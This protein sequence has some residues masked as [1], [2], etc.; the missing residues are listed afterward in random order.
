[1]KH[2]LR[3][4]LQRLRLRRLKADKTTTKPARAPLPAGVRL[5]RFLIAGNLLAFIA[6]PIVAG[7]QLA[8]I[9]GLWPQA[10]AEIHL[11]P[12]DFKPPTPLVST[13]DGMRNPFDP[14][15]KPWQAAAPVVRR[16][17][18]PARGL[19]VTPDMHI[20]FSPEGPVRPGQ[21]LP[22]GQLRA[23]ETDRILLDTPLGPRSVEPPGRPHLH[24]EQLNRP[25][26]PAPDK[27]AR[28]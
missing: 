12:A 1:M 22:E 7:S 8:R 10:D 23:I 17:A 14:D 20:L 18:G 16:A 26:P 24:L 28:P 13:L 3:A 19:I 2:R 25:R 4:V 21:T 9:Y 15:G 6:L 11:P 27:E 5:T